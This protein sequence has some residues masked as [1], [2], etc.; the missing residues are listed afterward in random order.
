IRRR[1]LGHR[2]ALQHA[3][4]LEP[5]IPVQPGRIVL[6]DNKAI[7]ALARRALARR[8]GGLLEVALLVV[9]G[10]RIG[11]LGVA[12]RAHSTL[13]SSG[14]VGN[15][16]RSASPSSVSMISEMTTP[17]TT[18]GHCPAPQAI[19]IIAVSHRCAAVVR[20]FTLPLLNTTN[21]APM[22]PMNEPVAS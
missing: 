14:S 8:L 10:Q 3:I 4:G 21:P 13:S 19:P 12:A 11:G 20:F 6:L 16:C 18:S 7:A 17:I 22:M 1:A 9:F 5:E 15:Q 2:P